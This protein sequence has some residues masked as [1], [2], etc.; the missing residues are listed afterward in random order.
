MKKK[1]MLLFLPLALMACEGQTTRVFTV[2]NSSDSE[3]FMDS[4]PSFDTILNFNILPNSSQEIRM[5]NNLG[6]SS[7]PEERAFLSSVYIYNAN[8]DTIKKEIWVDSNWTDEIEELKKV[9]STWRHD[10]TFEMTASDF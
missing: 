9:P 10:Y 3:V 5:T 4:V 1:F 8:A 6:G 7:F 2:V